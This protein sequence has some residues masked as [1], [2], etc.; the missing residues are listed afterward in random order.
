MIKA[1][2][3]FVLCH[4]AAKE[5]ML[6]KA[7]SGEARVELRSRWTLGWRPFV[8]EQKEGMFLLPDVCFSFHQYPVFEFLKYG[9]TR[10][11]STAV[12]I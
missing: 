3:G 2:A 11:S 10:D 12:A 1:S 6:D 7:C 9:A 5:L 8:F 4:V